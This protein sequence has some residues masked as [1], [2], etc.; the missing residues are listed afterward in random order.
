MQRDVLFSVDRGSVEKGLYGA[1]MWSP[2]KKA[3]EDRT[4]FLGLLLDF[5]GAS[6]LALQQTLKSLAR[7]KTPWLASAA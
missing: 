3:T 7:A 2:F 6:F 5:D 4:D 1:I